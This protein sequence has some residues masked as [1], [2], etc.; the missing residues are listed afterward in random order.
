M[1]LLGPKYVLCI[2]DSSIDVAVFICQTAQALR[3]AMKLVNTC[4][5]YCM[6]VADQEWL[7]GYPGPGWPHTVWYL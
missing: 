6:R 3:S 2:A 1:F 5:L 7:K 4:L